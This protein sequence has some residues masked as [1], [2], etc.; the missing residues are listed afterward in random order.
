MANY[1]LN[2]KNFAIVNMVLIFSRLY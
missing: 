2:I 1:I